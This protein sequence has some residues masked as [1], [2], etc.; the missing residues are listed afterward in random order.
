MF[1]QR[2]KLNY[3]DLDHWIQMPGRR[4]GGFLA[5]AR[6][7]IGCVSFIELDQIAVNRILISLA[8]RIPKAGDF[9]SQREAETRSFINLLALAFVLFHS[10]LF[11]GVYNINILFQLK[12]S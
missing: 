11:P 6:E 5:E 8:G 10:W 7:T 2:D 12:I 3:V 9:K 1:Y 4:G